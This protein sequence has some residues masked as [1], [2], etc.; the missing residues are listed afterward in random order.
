MDFLAIG[1]VVV[2]TFIR[3][4]EA[5]VHCD[6]NNEHCTI[7]MRFGD[8]IPFEF[9]KV[10][11]GVGNAPNGAVAASR[12]GL[13]AALLAAVGKD[14]NGEECIAALNKDK[15]DTTLVAVEDGKETNSHY[16]LWYGPE[17]TILIKHE[18]FE[19]ALPNPLPAP[20]VVYL[21]SV[22]EAGMSLHDPLADWLEQAP[23][24]LFAFQPGTFQMKAGMQRLA[25]IY[26]RANIFVANKEEYQRILGS[27]EEDVK[28]LMHIM[29]TKGPS[30]CFLTDGPQGAYASDG[31][32]AYKIGL[33]PDGKN[34]YER[35]G[36]G[37][38]FASTAVVALS[39]G[40]TLP[41]ALAWGPV[42]SASVVQKIGAQE[43]LLMRAD[44][45]DKLKNA[46]ADY[47]A[48]SF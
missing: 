7:S 32:N 28:K 36:A 39:L 45:E 2:D 24:I 6:I 46:P 23:E 14:R 41:E 33:Y 42:N 8:K 19:Y 38:A 13:K 10:I 16:V 37:D 35:T 4:K 18:A 1:D 34:A 26:K 20:K 30:I 25:R 3:L 27:A 48:V 17:R 29:H 40:K 44:L 22:G 5:E 12:L 15:V 11:A 9:A 31:E 21:S 43:G 47:K